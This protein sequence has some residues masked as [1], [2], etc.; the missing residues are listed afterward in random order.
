[1]SKIAYLIAVHEEPRMLKRLVL[2]LSAPWARFFVHIDRRVPAR[3]FA[4]ALSGIAHVEFVQPRV[5]VHWGGWSQLEATLRLMRRALA[6]DATLERFAL[7]SGACYPLRRNE[8][9]R[10]FLFADKSEYISAYPMPDPVHDKPLT[11][12]TRWHVEGGFR[13]T[14]AKARII[15]MLNDSLRLLPERNLCSGLDGLVPYAGSSWWVLTRQSAQSILTWTEKR[16][17]LVSFLRHSHC[18]DECFFQTILANSEPANRIAGTLTYADWS[19]PTEQPRLIRDSHLAQLLGRDGAPFFARK[20]SSANAPL[21]DRIDA[22][23]GTPLP[24]RR[25][26]EPEPLL[27]LTPGYAATP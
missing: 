6:Q 9:L 23:R 17:Q 21:L 24:A 8:A 5:S 18:P 20:F 7:L 16:P 15:R 14:G 11:R 1:V 26:P 22:A 2:A 25:A 13:S 4:E 12:L 3:P 19:D 10:D 27:G